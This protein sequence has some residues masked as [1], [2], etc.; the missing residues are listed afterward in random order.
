M[1]G[2]TSTA[3]EPKLHSQRQ[4]FGKRRRFERELVLRLASLLWR[5]R[6]AIAT[7]T[8]LLETSS[9]RNAAP[10]LESAAFV[11]EQLLMV[12]LRLEVSRTIH[13]WKSVMM[14]A[15]M[16]RLLP[17]C[18]DRSRVLLVPILD[19]PIAICGGCRLGH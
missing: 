18:A 9:E 10:D 5:L 15:R 14:K 13:H 19:E 2:N 6:R 12:P 16:T 7:D 3:N 1:A 11:N 17:F 8:G 4:R